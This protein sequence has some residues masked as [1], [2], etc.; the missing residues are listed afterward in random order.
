[1]NP[2]LLRSC[3]AF[4]KLFGYSAK[5]AA[6]VNIRPVPSARKLCDKSILVGHE[7]L[8]AAC[9]HSYLSKWARTSGNSFASNV[10]KVPKFA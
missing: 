5:A 6:L 2:S 7:K 3:G 10:K 8:S 4:G 9:D 1:M